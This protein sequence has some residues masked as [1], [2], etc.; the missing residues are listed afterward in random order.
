MNDVI[1]NRQEILFLYEARDCNPNGDPIDENRPRTDP[2][3]GQ[4]TVT[5][6]RIKRTVRD[7]LFATM[8]SREGYDILVRD[9]HNPD[10]TLKDGKGRCNDFIA[11]SGVAA[12]AGIAELIPAVTDVI[13]K[14]CID[15]RLFGTTLPVQKGSIKIT[16]PVQFSA[17]NRSLHSV[18]PVFIQQTAAFASKEGMMQKSFAERWILPYALIAAYGVV[19]EVAAKTTKLSRDDVDLLVKGLWKGTN[20]LNT[21]SKMGHQSMLLVRINYKPGYRIGALP[22]RIFLATEKEETAMRSAADYFI[23]ITGLLSAMADAKD[24]IT[25]V[26]A[27]WDDRLRLVADGKAGDFAELAKQKGISVNSLKI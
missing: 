17:F 1:A 10:G 25:G 26:D 18:S 22:E 2:E 6:V 11:K 16:G 9:T 8:G 5:D 13:L 19:N 20:G 27:S 7:Y 23:D 12:N 15:A 14:K 4:A 3:T 24:R 21:H